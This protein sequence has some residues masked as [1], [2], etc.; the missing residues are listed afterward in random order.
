MKIWICGNSHTVALRNG[1]NLL[2]RNDPPLHVF[3]LGSGKWAWE[4]FAV[5]NEF[6][7]KFSNDNY[8]KNFTTVTNQSYFNTDDMYGICIG[9]HSPRL[10]GNQAWRAGKPSC[11]VKGK[12]R[13]YSMGV[14]DA[15]INYDQKYILNFFTLLKMANVN[16]FV[17]S[18]PPPPSN[19]R[20]SS[21]GNEREAIRFIESRARKIFVDWL[22]TNNIDYVDMP[23]GTCTEEG[24]LK[25]EYKLEFRFDGKRDPHHANELYGAEVLKC[26]Y[27]YLDQC[28]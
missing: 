24:F 12:E 9:G 7:V 17:I 13:P 19:Y 21:D 18:T 26:V 16:F 20:D 4:E 8:Y 11:L 14:L 27:A 5:L 23:E 10:Y 2:E 1:K 22:S 3:P 6:G 25:P 15:M 28:N